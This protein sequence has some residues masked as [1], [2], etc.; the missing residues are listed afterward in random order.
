MDGRV[1]FMLDTQQQMQQI[2]QEMQTQ[3]EISWTHFSIYGK[4]P[5]LRNMT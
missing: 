2:N 3:H 4:S 1:R 5:K